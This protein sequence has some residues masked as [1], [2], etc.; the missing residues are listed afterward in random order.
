MIRSIKN[1][2]VSYSYG[3][4]DYEWYRPVSYTHL[5]VYKRQ[6][7]KECGANENRVEN[8]TVLSKIMKK[9]ML[10]LNKLH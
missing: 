9:K 8:F 7:Y 6:L 1:N 5:D 3:I 2:S 10:S 4:I